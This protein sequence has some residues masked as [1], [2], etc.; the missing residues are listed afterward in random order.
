MMQENQ[1]ST[2]NNE[3]QEPMFNNHKEQTLDFIVNLIEQFKFDKEKYLVSFR[4]VLKKIKRKIMKTDAS[5]FEIHYSLIRRYFFNS[6]V[7][8]FMNELDATV[9]EKLDSK[10]L[11]ALDVL[12]RYAEVGKIDDYMKD[13][14][15]E[16][17]DMMSS[18]IGESIAT[19]D[20][21]GNSVAFNI[22]GKLGGTGIKKPPKKMIVTKAYRTPSHN[23]NMTNYNSKRCEDI[24]ENVEW[25]KNTDM[26]MEFCSNGDIYVTKSLYNY[27]YES[28]K[29]FNRNKVLTFTQNGSNK[30][31]K[32]KSN[33]VEIALGITDDDHI[34]VQLNG[35]PSD[36]YKIRVHYKE[37]N[38]VGY[39]IVNSEDALHIN[40]ETDFKLHGK[41]KFEIIDG[42]LYG[43]KTD[44]NNEERSFRDEMIKIKERG[45]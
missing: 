29:Y 20:D 25:I 44:L 42:M 37:E 41:Y 45:E 1:K 6:L 15:K 8:D 21:D 12:A 22:P 26:I 9:G 35:G 23:S 38:G 10:A 40:I 24:L 5:I 28:S 36:I 18:M 17:T 33:T 13:K 30:P 43:T 7:S 27:L 4:R 14:I 39:G 34:V 31:N 3:E 32:K 11:Y 2:E 19:V 16:F